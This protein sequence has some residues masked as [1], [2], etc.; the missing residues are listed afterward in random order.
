MSNQ[1][2]VNEINCTKTQLDLLHVPHY[3]VFLPTALTLL[4]LSSDTERC[5]HKMDKG[6]KPEPW[7]WEFL[8]LLYFPLAA[9]YQLSVQIQTPVY[10]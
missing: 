3:T 8:V 1:A 2:F 9:K 4:V 6:V 10:V 7:N 5:R